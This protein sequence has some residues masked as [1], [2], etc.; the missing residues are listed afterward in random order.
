MKMMN[1]SNAG[2][3]ILDYPLGNLNSILDYPW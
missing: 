3:T 2:V 1:S